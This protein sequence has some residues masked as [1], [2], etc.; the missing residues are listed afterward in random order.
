MNNPDTI[1]MELGGTFCRPFADLKNRLPSIKAYIFDWDGVF[2]DGVKSSQGGSLF[3]E[4]DAMGTNMLR[5]GHWLSHGQLP[6]VAIITGEE[7]PA[8]QHLA[9]R[10]K[11]DAIYSKCSNKLIA[12]DHFLKTYALHEEEVAFVFDDV[13]DLAVADR[14]GLRCMVKHHAS[15]MLQQYVMLENQAEYISSGHAHGVREICELILSA[16][17][18][19]DEAVSLRSAF[20]PAYQNYLQERQRTNVKNFVLKEG[21]IE[22]HGKTD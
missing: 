21:K 5:F 2:N 3:S 11:F 13:L 19:Y 22:E 9:Q 14:C 4:V 20:A 16:N 7:N 18:K 1:F 15:P 12:F 10:E 8:A 17:K 6:R